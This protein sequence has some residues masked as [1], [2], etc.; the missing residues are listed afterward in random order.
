[1]T[2]PKYWDPVTQTWVSFLGPVG[3]PGPAGPTGPSGPYGTAGGDL[4]GTYPNPSVTA[5]AGTLL[6]SFPPNTGR[7]L[8]YDG[9]RIS[10]QPAVRVIPGGTN[11]SNNYTP[12]PDLGEFYPIGQRG[13]NSISPTGNFTINSPGGSYTYDGQKLLFRI[14]APGSYS[15]T[16]QSPGYYNSGAVSVPTVL[17]GGADTHVLFIFAGSAGQWICMA[18]DPIG[19]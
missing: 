2:T 6:G 15:I 5:L 16:W 10:P 13:Q 1:M 19:Y 7:R 9:S 3:P 4:S 14:W 11:Q 17:R 12:N 8:V 18:A